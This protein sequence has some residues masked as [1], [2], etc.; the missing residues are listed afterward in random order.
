MINLYKRKPIIVAEIGCNHKGNFNIAKQMIR[1]AKQCGAD[2]VKFKRE[3]IDTYLVINIMPHPVPYNFTEPHMVSTE[4]IW[5]LIYQLIKNY[6]II[7]KK[8]HKIFSICLGKIQ[9]LNL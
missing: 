2:Y 3:I 4:I 1:E 6:L 9:Q 5:N 8:W 7:V